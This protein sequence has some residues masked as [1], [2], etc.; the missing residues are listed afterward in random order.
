MCK[1]QNSGSFNSTYCAVAPVTEEFS[2]FKVFVLVLSFFLIDW[3]SFIFG[4]AVSVTVR[5]LS[6][7]AARG[8]CSPAVVRG[9]WTS[10]A[11]VQEPRC[12]VPCGVF[13]DKGLNPCALHWWVDS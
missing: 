12:S 8:G 4:C 7:G 5:G 13:L 2:L 3:F 1:Q 10:G 9:L 11:G 6:L